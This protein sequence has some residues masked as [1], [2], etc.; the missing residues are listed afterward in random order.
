MFT[1]FAITTLICKHLFEIFIWELSL[2]FFFYFNVCIYIDL[3]E[4]S[5]FI[6]NIMDEIRVDTPSDVPEE[7]L[8]L[9]LIAFDCI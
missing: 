1:F 4:V 2:L 5:F 6:V 3:N 8:L 7:L 9:F